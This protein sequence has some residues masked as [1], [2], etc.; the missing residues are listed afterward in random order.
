M[1]TKLYDDKYLEILQTLFERSKQKS[2]DLL[3]PQP[4]ETIAD[5]GCG[6][7]QDAINI[8][9]TGAKVYGIDNDQNFIALSN[10]QLTGNI[11]VNFIC[12]NA[13]K[14][15]LANH[16]IDSFRFDRVLQHIENHNKVLKEVTRLLKPGGKLIIV[17]ADYLSVSLF[18]ED[19]K[20]E[21]K[22][23]DAIAY[24]RIPNSHKIRQ[25]PTTLAQNNFSLVSTEIH[26]YI[27]NDY[28]FAKSLIRF[29]KTVVEEFELGNISQ[30]E[31]KCWQR[32]IKRP[33]NLSINLMLFTAIKKL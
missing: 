2:Y 28:E 24:N 27:I 26:N 14:I 29:D 32:H 8:A 16:S 10:Q 17:D 31:K 5:I 11:K 25:L 21:R 4:Y 19:E 33:F 15:P 12:C 3:D 13:D 20:L 18:L 1:T 7:G 22:I 6:I 23:I 9:K 30:T